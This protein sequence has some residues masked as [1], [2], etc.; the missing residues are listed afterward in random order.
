MHALQARHRV[1]AELRVA[2]VERFQIDERV[3]AALADAALRAAEFL[4]VREAGESGEPG[5]GDVEVGQEVQR[6][7]EPLQLLH[8]G[9]HLQLVVALRGGC[10]RRE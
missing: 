5:V 7:L 1:I 3:E 10:R 4:Q 6:E 2:H 9:D 8:A